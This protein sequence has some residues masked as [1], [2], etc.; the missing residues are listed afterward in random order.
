MGYGPIIK[1]KQ[2]PITP[3]INSWAQQMQAKIAV[4]PGRVR[5][6]QWPMG[7]SVTRKKS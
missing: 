2:T 4:P 6:K 7:Q 1:G 5:D 3:W